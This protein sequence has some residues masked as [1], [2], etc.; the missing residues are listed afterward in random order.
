MTTRRAHRT[1]YVGVVKVG[2]RNVW[3]SPPQDNRSDAQ[4]YAE[5]MSKQ[6]RYE[7]GRSRTGLKVSCTTRKA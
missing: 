1:R 6:Y 4:R 7:G 2:S 5:G 3:T